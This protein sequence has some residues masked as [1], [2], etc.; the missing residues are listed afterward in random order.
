MKETINSIF[1]YKLKK[2][3]MG[4]SRNKSYP[5]RHFGT[6][7]YPSHLFYKNITR[8]FIPVEIAENEK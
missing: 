6:W 8:L 7:V 3:E 1:N 2:E 4:E 5:N